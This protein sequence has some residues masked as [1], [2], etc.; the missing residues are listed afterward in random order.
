MWNIAFLPIWFPSI[1]PHNT[2]GIKTLTFCKSASILAIKSAI[3][4]TPFKRNPYLWD[5]F[6]LTDFL[7]NRGF[8]VIESVQKIGTFSTWVRL[9]LGTNV[10]KHKMNAP[11]F[12]WTDV[13]NCWIPIDWMTANVINIFSRRAM[14]TWWVAVVAVEMV[15]G[16]M[17]FATLTPHF[18]IG[19]SSPGSGQ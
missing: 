12:W 13:L 9:L 2:S 19:Q 8:T 14:V 11:Q 16:V 7:L 5:K 3:R 15:L 4:K 10:L 18:P 17:G 6:G 1:S